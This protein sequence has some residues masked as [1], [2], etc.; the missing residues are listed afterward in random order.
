[1]NPEPG[2]EQQIRNELSRILG[3]PEFANAGRVGPFLRYA[4]ERTLAGDREGLKESVIGTEVF[5]RPPGYD[6][7][8]DP[9]VR[10]EA[11]RLRAKL[12]EYGAR[13]PAGDVRITIPKGGYVAEFEVL[14]RPGEE[15]K[16]IAP[17][18]PE[19][20]AVV[21]RRRLLPWI[22]AATGLA[23]AVAGFAILSRTG[24]RGGLPSLT[25]VTSYPGYQFNP[26]LSPDGS[27]VTFAW[28][29]ENGG[30][31]R[32]YVARVNGGE[33]RRITKDGPGDTFPV[34]S[35][36]GARIAFVRRSVGLIVASPRGGDE[37]TLVPDVF[38]SQ[39][40]WSPDGR[41][42]VYSAFPPE[43]A[44][45]SLYSADALTGVWRQLPGSQR[46]L[47]PAYSPDGKNLAFAR[48]VVGNCEVFT[49]PSEGGEARQVTHQKASISG[50]TWSPD[51]REIVFASRRIGA[52]T[53]WRVAAGGSD[54]LQ[55]VI[56]AGED[57]RY[58]R[59]GPARTGSRR[60][61]YEQ[62]ISDSNI[63]RQA[64]ETGKDGAVKFSGEPRRLISSTR[65]DGSPQVSPDGRRIAFISTRTGFEEL[66]VVDENG[67][68]A[69]QVTQMRAQGL[70]SPRW[71]PD[72]GRL[73]FD[74]V[75]G[76]GRAIYI[77]DAAGGVPRRWTGY[78]VAGRTSWSRDGRWLYLSEY[79]AKHVPQLLRVSAADP[80]QRTPLGL[81]GF[82]A[83]ESADATEI[84]FI[85]DRELRRAP[86]SGGVSTPV[87]KDLIAHG[88]WAVGRNG[89]YYV[90]MWDP[91]LYSVPPV[92][93]GSKKVYFLDPKSGA[94]R[95]IGTIAGDLI[96]YYPDFC[97]S[98]DE[99][100]IYYSV[101]EIS[102]SQIRMIEGAF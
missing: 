70:G 14:V 19:A 84:F 102:V 12:E 37:R 82:E 92:S 3:S 27:E 43:S 94:R 61:V 97:V 31:S 79:D 101:I 6:P 39:I 44:D 34:W 49:M 40:D 46:G 41:R 28:T 17:V 93:K 72:S 78:H 77:V 71:S 4:V 88:W 67:G 87:L 83:L 81:S 21:P 66:W 100:N 57:T 90:D 32:I 25:T 26:S 55:S 8:T 16:P 9:I 7:K 10:T 80:E 64:L 59:F 68:N 95:Q 29:G 53:L 69:V 54:T 62:S 91:A 35:P 30:P 74:A 23:G 65:I 22:L 42:I 76:E 56:L 45:V 33:P 1:M 51:G 52:T 36:D 86:W 89:I 18:V 60:M 75:T 47:Y 5:G 11:R 85:R 15:P 2:Q 24:D 63:W 73:S 13:V 98:P 99:R 58:P 50:L 20:P 96:G 38:T 48:C